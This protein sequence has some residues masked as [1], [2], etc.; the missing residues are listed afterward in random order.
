MLAAEFHCYVCPQLNISVL[1]KA[2]TVSTSA[3]QA[4]TGCPVNYSAAASSAALTCSARA[5]VFLSCSVIPGSPSASESDGLFIALLV[6]NT[7]NLRPAEITLPEVRE[8][9]VCKTQCEMKNLKHCH[10]FI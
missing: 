9:C 6:A 10:S 5:D 1:L 7:N 2:S 8:V 3:P 4:A